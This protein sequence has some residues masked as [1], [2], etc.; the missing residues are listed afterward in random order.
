MLEPF[1]K[2]TVGASITALAVIAYFMARRIP[3]A[4]PPVPYMALN[5]NILSETRRILGYAT[6]RRDVFEA[7]LGISWFWFVGV[8]MLTLLPPF[9][10]DVLQAD[11][12]VAN[13]FIAAFTVGIGAGSLLASSLLKRR[14]IGSLRAAC[15]GTHDGLSDR[16]VLRRKA[17]AT[18]ASA[19]GSI[20][21]S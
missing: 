5:W 13:L 12:A 18:P 7:I 19:G 9:T 20:P 4:P 14:S 10:R 21:N 3:A 11:A 15:G 6:E 2:S 1:G 8:M 17:A 16:S